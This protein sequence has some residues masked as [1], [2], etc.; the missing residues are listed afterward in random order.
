M[1]VDLK[2]IPVFL[3]SDPDTVVTH[4]SFKNREE[5]VNF[6]YSAWW[7]KLEFDE[8]AGMDLTGIDLSNMDLSHRNFWCSKMTGANLSGS[9]LTEAK[10]HETDL[11]GANL[12]FCFGEHPNMTQVQ[13]YYPNKGVNGL[14]LG[15]PK[16]KN[17]SLR[18]VDFFRGQINGADLT[19]A[20]LTGAK[21]NRCV[22]RE[23]SFEVANFTNADLTD[24]D[25]TDSVFLGTN[26]TDAQLA[27][28]RHAGLRMGRTST[29]QRLARH[30]RKKAP[31][32]R[33]S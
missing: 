18:H 1:S 14:Q 23:T 27:K 21:L 25:I 3:R 15:G 4:L 10:F 28:A 22:I 7:S 32:P 11:T 16:M 9:N 5:L 24:S 8:P 31:S 20:N 33:F 29:A 30:P 12:D 26:I 13:F 19:G 2:N 6:M 17:A